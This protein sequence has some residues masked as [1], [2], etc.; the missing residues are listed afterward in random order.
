MN[1]ITTNQAHLNFVCDETTY[2]DGL[3]IGMELLKVCMRTEYLSATGLA[4]NQIGGDKKVYI[5]KDGHGGWKTY[6][7]AEIVSSAGEI[8]HTESCMSLPKKKHRDVK[9]TRS[10]SIVVNHLVE[11]GMIAER[12]EGFMACVHQHEIDH[13]NGITIISKGVTK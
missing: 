9:I 5:V 13:L 11:N 8:V 1:R 6:I 3:K 12:I 4:H 10:I 2:E 7:N